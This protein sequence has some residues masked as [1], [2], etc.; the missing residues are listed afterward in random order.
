MTNCVNKVFLGFSMKR[1]YFLVLIFLLS[2]PIYASVVIDFDST[3]LVQLVIFIVF[4]LI[5]Q[6]L[7]INP[8]VNIIDRREEATEGS[9]EQVKEMEDKIL[10]LSN[11]YDT[12]IIGARKEIVAENDTIIDSIQRENNRLLKEEN[13]KIKNILDELNNDLMGEKKELEKELNL[14]IDSLATL[15]VKKVMG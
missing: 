3:V 4:G 5:M 14:E 10:Q 7:I 11:E 12:K 9:R 15:I 1:I 13:N 2:T 6:K 8:V